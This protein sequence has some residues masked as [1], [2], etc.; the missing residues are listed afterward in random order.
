MLAG[1]H[2]Q[3]KKVD[4]VSSLQVSDFDINGAFLHEPLTPGNSPRQLVMQLPKNIPHPLAGQWV[5]IPRAVYGLKQSN[6][7]FDTSL[8]AVLKSGGFLPTD[9]EPSIKIN[10]ADSILSC[11]VAMHADDGLICSTYRPYYDELMALLTNRYGPLA[12]NEECTSN[13][14]YSLTCYAKGSLDVSQEGY[15][16]RML[17]N[18]GADS[19][20]N[21]DSPSLPDL[22]HAPTD[23]T[24]IDAISYKRILNVALTVQCVYS[25]HVVV[26]E[27]AS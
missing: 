23:L 8:T 27:K 2:A 5:E 10:P 20:P 13:T 22:F 25:C 7:S 11:A 6:N 3:A 24:P 14:A 15:L 12:M 19:L 18:L 4:R 26:T 9:A 1:Y 17:H 21:V 16:H